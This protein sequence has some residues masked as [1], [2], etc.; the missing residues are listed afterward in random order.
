MLDGI[1]KILKRTISQNHYYAVT[2]FSYPV[3]LKERKKIVS[4]IKNELLTLNILTTGLYGTWEYKWSDQA[5][6][7]TQKETYEFLDLEK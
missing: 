5:Y 6:F 2:E 7:D 4:E 1:Q 3:P